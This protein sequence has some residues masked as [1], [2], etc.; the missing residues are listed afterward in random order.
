MVLFFLQYGVRF[1]LWRYHGEC[2]QYSQSR[3]IYRYLN[4]GENEKS[5]P[6]IWWFQI[7]EPQSQFYWLV[8]E[9]Y[10]SE[11]KSVGMIIPNNYMEK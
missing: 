5:D 1:S 2:S 9:P 7:L 3:H 11:Q 4:H 6:D 10:P 8:V